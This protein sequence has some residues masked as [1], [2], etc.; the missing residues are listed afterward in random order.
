M[1]FFELDFLLLFLPGVLV[2]YHRILT[3]SG[4]RQ[5]L[6]IAASV[7]FYGYWDVTF[8]PLLLFSVLANWALAMAVP[9]ERRALLIPAAF[10]INLGL[11]AYFKYQGFLLENF[12]VLTSAQ[13]SFSPLVLPLG[14]S[15]F[16]FQQIS[17]L[18]DLGQARA[19][20][21]G[22]RD[23]ALFVTFF[24]QLIAGPIVR[25]NQL[26][27]QFH[28]TPPDEILKERFAKGLLFLVIGLV[29]KLFI[30]DSA[31]II[32]DPVFNAAAAGAV[33]MADA[34]LGAVAFSVQL[35]FDFSAYSD[36]AI[37]LALMVGYRL[38]QNFNAPYRAHSLRDFWRRWHIT[39]SSWLRDYVYFPLGGSRHGMG[40]LVFAIMITMGLCGLWHGAGWTFVAWG[41]WHGVG[42][43][44]NASWRRLDIPLPRLLG[45]AL[46]MIFVVIGWVLFRA[47]TFDSFLVMMS[48]LIGADGGVAQLPGFRV[49]FMLDRFRGDAMRLAVAAVYLLPGLIA[50]AGPTTQRI[51][52]SELARRPLFAA[53]VGLALAVSIL[54]SAA[55]I[56]GEF[57][58]FQF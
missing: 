25:H 15:F 44:V 22:L 12:A 54:Q 49:H 41:L 56:S 1:L 23:Y 39:L 10:T 26:I 46:T 42:L 11:L 57:I 55:G 4:A 48:S 31:A 20:R 53:V 43:T 30:A 47:Q 58:Y 27:P 21:Y 28:E 36:M 34:W 32:A 3:S 40:R 38:P 50:L 19:P 17:Y 6:L 2:L 37:G 5:W 8:V 13:F 18:V 9:A 35:Y 52:D 16:T 45:W 33:G 14:I 7:A 24:P 51:V 29:K